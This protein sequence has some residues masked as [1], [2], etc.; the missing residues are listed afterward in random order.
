VLLDD[1]GSD[2]LE[3]EDFAE[4]IEFEG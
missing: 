2:E 4:A 3:D 1:P